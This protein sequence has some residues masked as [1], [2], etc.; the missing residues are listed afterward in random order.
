MTCRDT[1]R[2]HS[3]GTTF[4]SVRPPLGADGS[5]SCPPG[6]F[7]RGRVRDLFARRDRA[8]VRER[9]FVCRANVRPYRN[10]I[11]RLLT[12]LSVEKRRVCFA[13]DRRRE[14][15]ARSRL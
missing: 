1:R 8:S 2:V 3:I 5:A 10:D 13:A 6:L 11:R 12:Q 9:A 4:Y 14:R 15:V 7:M